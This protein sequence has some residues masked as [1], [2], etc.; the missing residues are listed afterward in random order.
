MSERVYING[1]F[2]KGERARISVFDR[3]LTYG[4]GLFETLKAYDGRVFRVREHLERLYAS[5][6]MLGISTEPIV[7]LVKNGRFPVIEKLLKLNN[8]TQGEAYLRIT[9]TRGVDMG[10]MPPSEGL[11]R[12]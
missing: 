1:R 9:L 5:A 7:R 11:R 3:G 10:G 6:E 2:V 4:D 12:R 8:L